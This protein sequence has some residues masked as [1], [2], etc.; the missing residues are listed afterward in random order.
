MHSSQNEQD[1]RYYARFAK[2]P[3]FEPSDSQEAKDFLKEAI[4]VS[5]KYKTPV[6]L[7]TNTRVSHSRTLVEVSER[8]NSDIPVDFKKDPSRWVPVPLWARGMRL[9][10]EDR[11]AGLI[12]ESN[13]SPLN[14]IEFNDKSLGVITSSISYQYVK[15]I[16]PDAS[17]LKLGFA[18]PYQDKLIK[19]FANK[20][21]KVLIVEELDGLIEEHVKAMGI[22]C[23]GREVIPGIGELTC[24]VLEKSKAALESADAPV[25][26]VSKYAGILAWSPACLMSRVSAPRNIYRFA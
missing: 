23:I 7:R 21:D 20:V 11:T 5:E 15:E 19:D 14:R 24:D 16:W 8:V 22:S 25:D 4:A 17:V 1:S 13:N 3:M 9:K 2:V 12:E 26:H 6:I 10:V 18:F